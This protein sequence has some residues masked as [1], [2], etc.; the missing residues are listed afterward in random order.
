MTP[1]PNL[2]EVAAL[3]GDPTRATILSALLGGQSLP[4][5][6]LAY[7]AQ[8]TPST[9]SSHLTKLLDGGLLSVTNTGRHRYYQLKGPDVAQVLEAMAVV[10]PLPVV[11]TPR[12][13]AEM[14]AIRHGR[15][16]Y[17]HLAGELGVSVTQAMVE[18]RLIVQQGDRFELTEKGRAWLKTWGIDEDEARKK[19]RVFAFACI[20]WTERRPHLGG[21][22][23][24]VVADK[25]FEQGWIVRDANSR[26][27]HLTT[28]G[29]DALK[30][31]F[32]LDAHAHSQK[33]MS[34]RT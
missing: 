10:A 15:T 33:P 20:D 31:E 29:R 23:G 22:L 26:A 18:G 30:R 12:E 14:E 4:A 19:R 32:G 8:V 27:V 28:S 1:E 21:A 3:I 11:K 25:F 16:C 9:M 17:D 34:E 2:W 6:E 5:S 13:S 7:Q 24:A